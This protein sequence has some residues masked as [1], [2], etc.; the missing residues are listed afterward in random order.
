MESD[1][2][3][4]AHSILYVLPI[5]PREINELLDIGHASKKPENRKMLLTIL[6]K[7]Q[8]LARQGLPLRG[9][10]AEDN[11][12]FMQLLQLRAKENLQIHEWLKRKNETYTS[13]DLQNEMIKLM[14]HA[15]LQ[16]I[17]S[18]LQQAQYYTLMADETTNSSNKEQLVTGFL[19]VD[20]SLQVH[21]E[22]SW[23]KP[24]LKLLSKC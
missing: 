10:G 12:N 13:K 19:C 15:C 23:I 20:E 14:A 21:E 3:T 5:E 4:E 8:F 22:I 6:Q 17:S 7:V 1:H 16:A 2:H 11:S 18:E 9:D 24:T